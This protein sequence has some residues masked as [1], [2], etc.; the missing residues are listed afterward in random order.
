MA[1]TNDTRDTCLRCHQQPAEAWWCD[2]CKA[3]AV[4]FQTWR[5]RLFWRTN[6]REWQNGSS[7]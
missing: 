6:T 4:D 2:L 1:T 5:T 3:C 7:R